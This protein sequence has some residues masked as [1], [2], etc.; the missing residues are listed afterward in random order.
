MNSNHD[1]YLVTEDGG[2]VMGHDA[3]LFLLR[4]YSDLGNGILERS[5]GIPVLVP[6]VTPGLD[7]TT[8]P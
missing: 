8:H 5:R 3:V 4:I 1:E 7:N 6:V 2:L